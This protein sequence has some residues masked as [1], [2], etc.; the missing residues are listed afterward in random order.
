MKQIQTETA[1]KLQSLLL[2]NDLKEIAFRKY[3]S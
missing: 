2:Q 3:F 1:V